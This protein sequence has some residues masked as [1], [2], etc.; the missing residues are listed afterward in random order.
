MEKSNSHVNRESI[1]SVVLLLVLWFVCMGAGGQDRTKGEETVQRL[2]DEGFENVR[3]SE[4]GEE[5]IYTIE[6]NVY[7][8]NGVG[9]RKALEIINSTGL[10]ENKTCRVI[11]TDYNIPQV[12]LTYEPQR[13]DTVLLRT[14]EDWEVSYDVDWESWKRVKKEKKQNSSLFKYDIVV[15]PKLSFMNLIITQIYQALF[16][17]CPTLEISCWPGMKFTGQIVLP[18]YNDGYGTINSKVH[19]C[20]ITV[21]QRFRLPYNISGR[22]IAGL[23]NTDR[24]GLDATLFHPFKDERF[25]VEGRIG[26]TG[27]G[28]WN[29][30]RYNYGTKLR[31]TWSVGGSFYWPRYNTQFSLKGEQ[32]LLQEKGIRFDMI[33]HFRYA[34]VGFYAM[35]AEHANSNGGFTFVVNPGIN[36]YKRRK[37]VPRVNPG[38]F[39]ILY[40][41]GNER[42]YYQTY[43]AEGSD[44]IMRNNRFNPFFIKSEILNY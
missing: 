6:N 4:T 3:W 39:G 1:Q 26:C 34:S 31:M 17:V 37:Y 24:Y 11:V 29:G 7:K 18:V 41:A 25:S 5:R 12:T 28:Y 19:P 2:V 14:V 32:Y 43:N 33:R 21:S 44:N 10:P 30:F 40:N 22:V 36:K 8:A 27:T 23:F 42:Y 38:D 9:L 20:Y 35:K 15:Y 16:T 13:G